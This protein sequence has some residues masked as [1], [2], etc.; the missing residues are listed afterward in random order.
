MARLLASS[1]SALCVVSLLAG[2]VVGYGLS[3]AMR[4]SNSATI[5]PA[6]CALRTAMRKLWSDHVFWTRNYIISSIAGL[7]D[8]QEVTGRL[9]KNQSDIGA[10]MATYYGPDGGKRLTELLKEHIS[11]AVEVVNAA[12]SNDKQELAK[13]NEKWHKNA[14]DIAKLLSEINNQWTYDALLKMLNMHLKLTS[15]ETVARIQKNWKNDTIAFDEVFNE[16]LN[17][18]DQLTAGIANQFP[19][20]F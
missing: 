8:L 15:D 7:E 10:A 9:L 1:P 2:A 5:S 17:M 6:R 14:Q 3:M 16:I 4:S 13:A 11:I 20:R 19:E 18:S 12:K